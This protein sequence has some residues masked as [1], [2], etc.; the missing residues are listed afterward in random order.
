MRIERTAAAAAVTAL[1]AFVFAGNAL[2]VEP[3]Q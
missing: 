1:A 2:A 3:N